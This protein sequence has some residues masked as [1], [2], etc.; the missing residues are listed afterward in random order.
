M[1]RLPELVRE[2][3]ETMG[4]GVAGDGHPLPTSYRA[5][6]AWLQ[7]RLYLRTGRYKSQ[8]QRADTAA[9][10][11]DA[12]EFVRA[13]QRFM[14]NLGIPV[15]CDVYAAPRDEARWFITGLTQVRPSGLPPGRTVSITHAVRGRDLPPI[16]WRIFEHSGLEVALKLGMGVQ[17]G[18]LSA[19]WQWV[20]DH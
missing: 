8:L 19:P 11:P 9:L 7:H 10:D 17:W 5:G 20:C 1:H 14:A 12:Y 13:F 18:G 15:V 3:Q 4:K 2:V 6:M 16:C